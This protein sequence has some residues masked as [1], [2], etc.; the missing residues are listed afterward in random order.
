MGKQVAGFHYRPILPRNPKA[1]SYFA[2]VRAPLNSKG[3]NNVVLPSRSTFEIYFQKEYW[4]FLLNPHVESFNKP[5]LP[6]DMS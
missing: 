3:Q 6:E 5:D 1:S 2:I 4:H